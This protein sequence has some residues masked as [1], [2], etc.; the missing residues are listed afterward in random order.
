[1]LP[2][3]KAKG[4]IWLHDKFLCE[5]EYEISEALGH[6]RTVHVQRI[7]LT[8]PEEHCAVLLDAYN[9]FLTLADGQR[10]RIPRPLQRLGSN[11]LECYVESLP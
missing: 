8:V 6:S 2:I 4:Q 9:L 3:E 1:M 7:M 10:H 11:Y 5:V